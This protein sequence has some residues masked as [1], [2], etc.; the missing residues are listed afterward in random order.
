SL[1][2]DDL[3]ASIELYDETRN[4]IRA[5]QTIRHRLSVPDFYAVLD[6]AQAMPREAFNPLLARLQADLEKP[7]P[8]PGPALCP[9]LYLV[10]A[11]L[12]EP[13]LLDLIHD[14]GARVVGD[15]LCTGSRH[16]Y[17]SV[18]TQ[19]DPI[20]ALAD[21]YLQR[22][23]CPSKYHPAHKPGDYLLQQAC[24]AGADGVVFVIEK[25]C[26]PHAFDYALNLPALDRAGLPHLMLEMEQTPSLEAL[27]TRLQAFVEML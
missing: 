27:R 23:P 3:R 15:D 25:F 12:D 13:D 24:Q 16:F 5:F 2:E 11:V 6:A 26:E 17:G 19:G 7:S 14:L 21:Y 18:G 10:G 9:S 20:A 1:N 8:Q 22:P 4:L